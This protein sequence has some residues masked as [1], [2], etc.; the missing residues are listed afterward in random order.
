MSSARHAALQQS[1]SSD[2]DESE[3]Q[4]QLCFGE[5]IENKGKEL[6]TAFNNCIAPLPDL[7]VLVKESLL[8]WRRKTFIDPPVNK[9]LNDHFTLRASRGL[10]GNAHDLLEQYAIQEEELRRALDYPGKA[11]LRIVDL[12]VDYSSL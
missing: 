5:T 1:M 7:H 9:D 2:S 11:L 10:M 6:A 3:C 12:A 8:S 4:V